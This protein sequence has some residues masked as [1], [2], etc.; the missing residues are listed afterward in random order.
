MTH[1][2]G[3][4]RSSYLLEKYNYTRSG[5]GEWLT[6]VLAQNSSYTVS[7]PARSES[8][9]LVGNRNRDTS[10]TGAAQ[11]LLQVEGYSQA[12]HQ[13]LYAGQPRRFYGQAYFSAHFSIRHVTWRHCRTVH[14][15]SDHRL[16][17]YR[18]VYL[19]RRCYSLASRLR[20]LVLGKSNKETALGVEEKLSRYKNMK[21]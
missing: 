4:V 13:W 10:T 7:P 6:V 1:L 18:C 8:P 9:L 15:R 17:M 16:G 19:Q 3:H 12:C 14:W 2:L 5:R 21:K 20:S 11:S